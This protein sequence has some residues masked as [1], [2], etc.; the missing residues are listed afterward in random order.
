MERAARLRDA[1][2]AAGNQPHLGD[3][4]TDAPLGPVD[5]RPAGF[6]RLEHRDRHVDDRRPDF[7]SSWR[8]LQLVVRP[9]AFELSRIAVSLGRAV[10]PHL[11]FENA[12]TDF[13]DERHARHCSRNHRRRFGILRRA[14][15][16]CLAATR[17]AT[18]AA[19]LLQQV[20]VLREHP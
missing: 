20:A 14:P 10:K 13:L 19:L 3:V 5:Q 6:G 2:T 11:G 8:A 15:A 17:A 16:E 7:R 4:I 9:K 12:D 1:H 18:K